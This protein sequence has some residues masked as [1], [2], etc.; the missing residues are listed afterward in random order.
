MCVCLCVFTFVCVS[1][2]VS[3]DTIH[4]LLFQSNIYHDTLGLLVVS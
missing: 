4:G 3:V 1:H 2:Y